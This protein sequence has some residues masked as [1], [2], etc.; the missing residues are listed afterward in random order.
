ML[1][2]IY[3]VTPGVTYFPRRLSAAGPPDQIGSRHDSNRGHGRVGN[4]L[5]DQQLC[6]RPKRRAT[7][8]NVPHPV[9]SGSEDKE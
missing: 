7:T 9:V 3:F 4:R 1:F 6:C 8:G 5:T 2:V